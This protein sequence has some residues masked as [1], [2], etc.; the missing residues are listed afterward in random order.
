M[1]RAAGGRRT[2]PGVEK[3]ETREQENRLVVG[4]MRNP[5]H[6]VAL[7]PGLRKGGQLVSRAFSCFRAKHQ[8]ALNVGTYFGTKGYE[9]PADELVAEWKGG[10]HHC[11]GAPEEPQKKDEWG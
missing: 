9:G 10:L 4:G 8:E 6:A 7:V 3:K 1:E 5:T 2:G 11:L